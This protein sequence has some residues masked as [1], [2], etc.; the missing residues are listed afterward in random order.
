MDGEDLP[1]DSEMADNG[2]GS[3]LFETEVEEGGDFKYVCS[4]ISQCINSLYRLSLITQNPATLPQQHE[5]GT[6]AQLPGEKGEIQPEPTWEGRQ[7]PYIRLQAAQWD[8]SSLFDSA[9]SLVNA[10]EWGN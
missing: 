3:M 5:K 9:R 2:Q 4:D 1:S 6:E 7:V 10:S 8:D